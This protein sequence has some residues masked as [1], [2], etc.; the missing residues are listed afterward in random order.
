[1]IP[2]DPSPGEVAWMDLPTDSACRAGDYESLRASGPRKPGKSPGGKLAFPGGLFPGFP[3]MLCIRVGRQRRPGQKHNGGKFC[4][5]F[6]ATA[7]TCFLSASGNI[8]R[9][10]CRGSSPA[11]GS[12]AEETPAILTNRNGSAVSASPP[13]RTAPRGTRRRAGAGR[14]P[15]RVPPGRNGCRRFA[16]RKPRP[17][18]G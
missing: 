18:A 8:R 2:L 1:M 4:Y 15:G 10:G 11:A 17:G 16:P 5:P 9:R 7:G 3:R 14:L 6:Q 12:G 13:A